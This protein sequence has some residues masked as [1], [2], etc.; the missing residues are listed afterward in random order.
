MLP[1]TVATRIV[2]GLSFAICRISFSV[3]PLSGPS[4]GPTQVSASLLR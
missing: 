2:P 3:L 1:G 4:V